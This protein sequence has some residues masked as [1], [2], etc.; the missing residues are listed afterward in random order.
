MTDIFNKIVTFIK[1]NI[2]L[3]I[4]ILVLIVIMFFSSRIRRFISPRRKRR[5]LPR[6]VGM[7]KTR[8]SKPRKQYTKGGKA[9][10]PWQIKGSEAARRHMRKIRAM[11]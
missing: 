11:R 1:N 10:K 2:L 5:S 6:S 8:R 7:H 4:L 9:K 3:S